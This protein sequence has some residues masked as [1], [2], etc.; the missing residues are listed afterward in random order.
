MATL[1]LASMEVLFLDIAIRYGLVV[2]IAMDSDG[3]VNT[4]VESGLRLDFDRELIKRETAL[5][6][7]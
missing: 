2:E 3:Y 6:V 4:P 1:N 7:R 5:V